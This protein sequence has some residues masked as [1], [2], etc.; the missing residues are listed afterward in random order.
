[1]EVSI[2]PLLEIV[3]DRP[4]DQKRTYRA[5][6]KAKLPNSL[7]LI[8]GIYYQT[9]RGQKVEDHEGGSHVDTLTE[10]GREE[11]GNRYTPPFYKQIHTKI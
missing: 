5:Y 11:V 8:N 3:P 6:M 9:L 1:M 10:V 4:T 7:F 2:P